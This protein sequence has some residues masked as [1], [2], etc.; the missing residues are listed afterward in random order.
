MKYLIPSAGR[1][2]TIE[3]IP[4]ILGKEN[5]LIYVDESEK[6]LYEDKVGKEMIRTHDVYGIGAIRKL[7]LDENKDEDFVFM[8]DDDITGFE[9]KFSTRITIIVDPEHIKN[10]VYNAYQPAYDLKTPMFGFIASL[11][12]MFYN[13]LHPV[14]FGGFINIGL[15]L[16]P[17]FL[18]DINF[19]PRFM[20][21]HEDHDIYLQTKYH[22]RF[23]FMDGRYS[24]RQKK[25]WL[26]EGGCSKLRNESNMR[27]CKELLIKRWSKR[28]CA[29]STRK[30]GQFIMK[31][32]F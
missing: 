25:A 5:L 4:K 23:I 9:Y 26:T 2:K 11:G 28:I 31:V 7:M 8:L 24:I 16:I 19:D 6:R 15:G 29:P 32:G 21:L 17:E 22:K 30:E 3:E 14:Y 27:Y 12:P 1:S 13:Q 18:G 20:C 10:I